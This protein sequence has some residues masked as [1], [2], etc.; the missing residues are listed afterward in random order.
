MSILDA[1][2]KWWDAAAIEPEPDEHTWINATTHGTPW[3][4]VQEQCVD[5]GEMR[6][7]KR[8]EQ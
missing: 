7:R 6:E 8:E 2:R 3:E 1:I 4:L 5:C